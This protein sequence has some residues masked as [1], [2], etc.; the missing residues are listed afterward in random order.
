MKFEK[1]EVV[2]PSSLSIW[3]NRLQKGDDTAIEEIYTRYSQKLTDYA[4]NRI[5][6][7]H[8]SVVDK[9][10]VVSSVFRMIVQKSKQGSF[11]KLSSSTDLMPF[12][13]SVV[14]C[15]TIDHIRK[16]KRKFLGL[17][18]EDV[19]EEKS[20]DPQMAA[21]SAET[22]SG[23]FHCL[24]KVVLKKIVK[25]KCEGKRNLEIA[26]EIGVSSKTVSRKLELIRRIWMRQIDVQNP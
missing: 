25:L 2:E 19:L 23:L 14:A 18:F 17:S 9:D 12:L 5:G 3:L 13:L 26:E 11:P 1:K 7:N 10:D 21:I 16:E 20:L 8:L 22:I 24:E 4:A 15:K 6:A